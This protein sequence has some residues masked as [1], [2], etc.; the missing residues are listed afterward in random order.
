MYGDS[1]GQECNKHLIKEKK[2]H[3][4]K[5]NEYIRNVKKIKQ[6][7]QNSIKFREM[8]EKIRKEKELKQRVREYWLSL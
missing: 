6:Q 1:I 3:D 8:E 7:I 5:K 4:L 2:M